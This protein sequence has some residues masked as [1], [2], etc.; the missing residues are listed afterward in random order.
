MKMIPGKCPTTHRIVSFDISIWGAS[1]EIVKQQDGDKKNS[2]MYI[3][4]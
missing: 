3:T 2:K 1:V 4:P